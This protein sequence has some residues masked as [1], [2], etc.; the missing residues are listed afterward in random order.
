MPSA[1][2][3]R[4]SLCSVHFISFCLTDIYEMPYAQTLCKTTV[5]IERR[6]DP[7]VYHEGHEHSMGGVV[8]NMS[9]SAQHIE[10]FF[11]PRGHLILH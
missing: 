4:H 6:G 8:K 10:V 3:P 7:A 9:S 11:L 1:T 2:L 5:G